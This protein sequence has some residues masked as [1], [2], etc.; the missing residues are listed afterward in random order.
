MLRIINGL[1]LCN[2]LRNERSRLL[3]CSAVIDLCLTLSTVVKILKEEFRKSN[4]VFIRL[5]NIGR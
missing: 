4:F 1:K 5:T 2:K 3:T